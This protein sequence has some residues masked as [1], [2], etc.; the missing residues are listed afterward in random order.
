MFFKF[1]VISSIWELSAQVSSVLRRIVSFKGDMNLERRGFD[2]CHVPVLAVKSAHLQLFLK[3]VPDFTAIRLRASDT[4]SVIWTVV[5]SCICVRQHQW[6][7]RTAR[8]QQHPSTNSCTRVCSLLALCRH[9]ERS[10]LHV[11]LKLLWIGPGF[12][13]SSSGTFSALILVG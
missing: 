9:H 8:M 2:S 13:L 6:R 5:M 7:E 3:S 11:F 12:G 4:K 1:F 10:P